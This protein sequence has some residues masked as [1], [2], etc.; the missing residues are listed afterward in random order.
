M[1]V[2]LVPAIASAAPEMSPGG[3]FSFLRDDDEFNETSNFVIA[4]APTGGDIRVSGSVVRLVGS[5][6]EDATHQTFPLIRRFSANGTLEQ[7]FDYSPQNRVVL[8]LEISPDGNILYAVSR[9]PGPS[10]GIER[11]STATGLVVGSF[12]IPGEAG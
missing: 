3:S 10:L 7:T 2:L 1:A 5:G 11:I 6:P 9:V 8:D 4:P 12:A